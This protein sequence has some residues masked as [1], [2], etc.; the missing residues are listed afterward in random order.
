MNARTL[1]LSFSTILLTFSLYLYLFVPD[2]WIYG[3]ICIAAGIL[4]IFVNAECPFWRFL[5]STVIVLGTLETVFLV[6]SIR[7]VEKSNFL[8]I[9]AKDALTGQI[10][11]S[12]RDELTTEGR[13]IA[14]PALATFLT[15]STRLGNSSYKWRL[16]DIIRTLLLLTLMLILIPALFYS[17]TFFFPA[18]SNVVNNTFDQYW[19]K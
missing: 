1:Q 12:A 10:L 11:P 9:E 15:I 5:A 17:I 7:L 8:N 2:W 18:L 3:S 16:I 14:L 13:L 4:N 6:W 19:E